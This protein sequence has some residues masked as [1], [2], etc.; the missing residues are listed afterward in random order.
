MFAICKPEM[1]ET[2]I[3]KLWTVAY[4]SPCRRDRI[5]LSGLKARPGHAFDHKPLPCDH[6]RVAGDTRRKIDRW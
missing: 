1:R 3:D 2:D 6:V 5:W 4:L